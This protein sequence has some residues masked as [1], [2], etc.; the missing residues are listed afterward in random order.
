MY[1]NSS[2]EDQVEDMRKVVDTYDTLNDKI[3]DNEGSDIYTEEDLSDWDSTLMDGLDE[4]EE[5]EDEDLIEETLNEPLKKD[6]WI[7]EDEEKPTTIPYSGI[8][9]RK[10]NSD[11]DLT[12]TY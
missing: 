1:K 6:D 7:I 12:I 9:V 5:W 8:Y 4:E 3:K 11:V 10:K 2:L